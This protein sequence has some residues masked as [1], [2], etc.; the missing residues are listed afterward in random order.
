MQIEEGLLDIR[1]I[2]YV[3]SKLLGVLLM[4]SVSA[5]SGVL[6]SSRVYLNYPIE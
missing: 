1:D 6:K 5:S 2:V 3:P 4:V